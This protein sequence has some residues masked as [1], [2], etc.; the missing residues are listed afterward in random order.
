MHNLICNMRQGAAYLKETIL[1][2][3][4]S[5][6][7][8]VLVRNITNMICVSGRSAAHSA[9]KALY[10]FLFKYFTLSYG[11][12]TA[13]R[14]EYC[15]IF[16]YALNRWEFWAILSHK[17]RRFCPRN[18]EKGLNLPNWIQWLWKSFSRRLVRTPY[19]GSSMI[20]KF[21]FNFL[22]CFSL[23]SIDLTSSHTEVY[24]FLGERTKEFNSYNL[25]RPSALHGHQP[26]Q[27][28]K[29]AALISNLIVD[30]HNCV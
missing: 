23:P 26:L 25:E 27:E 3:L 22:A 15:E 7:S 20:F 5:G 13:I 30:A 16:R 6:D 4:H 29:G 28:W 19:N 17:L 11:R 10:F 24:S 2:I 9:H 12:L 14:C 21:S 1:I 8:V 18:G